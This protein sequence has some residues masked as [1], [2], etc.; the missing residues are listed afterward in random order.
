MG[1]S[2]GDYVLLDTIDETQESPKIESEES[3]QIRAANNPAYKV[4]DEASPI[5]VRHLSVHKDE[6]YKKTGHEGPMRS[7][8]FATAILG[9]WIADKLRLAGKPPESPGNDD[10]LALK[11]AETSGYVLKDINAVLNPGETTLIIGPSSSG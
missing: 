1:D 5:A 2:G 8:T 7:P 4:W 6:T 11:S 3:F 10:D 9:F